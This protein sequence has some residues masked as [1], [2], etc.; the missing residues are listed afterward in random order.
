MRS[1]FVILIIVGLVL[2]MNAVTGELP[3][4]GQV[5]LEFSMKVNGDVYEMTDFGEP[6]QIAVW[7]Q[8]PDSKQIKTVWVTQRSGRRLWKGKIECQTALPLWESRHKTEKSG[9]KGRGLIKRLVDAISGATPKAGVFKVRTQVPAGIRI[10]C[11]VEVNLSGDFNRDFPYR[12]ANGMPD[13]EINGQP[14]LIYQA[15]ITAR[16][17]QTTCLDLVGRTDQWIAVDYAIPDLTGITSAKKAVMDLKV[18][19]KNK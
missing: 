18:I 14:S 3:Q 5:Y 1:V 6:P 16:P 12:D 4:S 7:I 15:E 2:N 10:D 19:C 11:F 17:G 9:Y 13:P 8:E